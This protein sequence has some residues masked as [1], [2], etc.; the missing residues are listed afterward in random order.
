MKPRLLPGTN[1]TSQQDG[2]SVGVL[3]VNEMNSPLSSPAVAGS[4]PL[5]VINTPQI[6][7]DREIS[8]SDSP[9]VNT[10]DRYEVSNVS[11]SDW[12]IELSTNT[13]TPREESV[14]PTIPTPTNNSPFW[15]ESSPDQTPN[16]ASVVATTYSQSSTPDSRHGPTAYLSKKT[17]TENFP[18]KRKEV[19][20][21]RFYLNYFSKYQIQPSNTATH[22][23]RSF[24]HRQMI[25]Q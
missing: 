20:W 3:F 21:R 7:P 8:Q 19:E 6:L 24:W 25:G 16:T 10:I 9:I 15:E 13:P 1:K 11:P 12:G 17:K 14:L 23:S 18:F 2:F 5:A 22:S 4:D